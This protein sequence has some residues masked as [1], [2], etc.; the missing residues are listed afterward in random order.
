MK[1][2][3][4]ILLWLCCGASFV[5]AY[6]KVMSRQWLSAAFL[7]FI[8]AS[9]VLMTVWVL[10]SL[11]HLESPIEPYRSAAGTAT[12]DGPITMHR[13]KPET[14][15]PLIWAFGLMVIAIVSVL[16]PGTGWQRVLYYVGDLLLIVV[17]AFMMVLARG[18]LVDRV[19]ADVNGVVIQNKITDSVSLGDDRADMSP[20][21]HEELEEIRHETKVV[22]RE[23]GAVKMVRVYG[24]RVESRGAGDHKEFK[25]RELVFYD[26]KGK[27]MM[28]LQ[29]PL[30]PEEAY[31]R[32]LDAIP[33]WTNLT[34]QE[35]SETK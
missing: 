25:R 31:R 13:S 7:L 6:L 14:N 22:W 4:F 3:A 20:E 27:A 16:N 15:K 9:V 24:R 29:D 2:P 21:E 23:V 33:H 28:R 10:Y 11:K 30:A 26:H 34:I 18:K 1:D 5:L 35:A 32:F 8:G 12:Q 17:I 19:V